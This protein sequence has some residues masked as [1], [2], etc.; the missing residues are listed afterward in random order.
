[1]STSAVGPLGWPSSWPSRFTPRPTRRTR[2]PVKR[3]SRTVDHGAPPSWLRTVKRIAA[4][5]CASTQL[6]SRTL[7]SMR[8]LRALL[9]SSRF[10]TVQRPRQ[11]TGFRIRLCR[12]EMSLGTRPGIAG[13]APPNITFSPAPSSR[14]SS[15]TNGPGPFQPPMA[16]VS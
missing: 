4:P 8:T 16:W 7:S 13:S 14:L 9:S 3:T 11:A 1:M 12:I 6:F 15:M 10:L 5:F 2:F